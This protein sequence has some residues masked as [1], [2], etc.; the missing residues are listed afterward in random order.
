M[1]LVCG[2][3]MDI[4]KI[5]VALHSKMRFYF[6]LVRFDCT[7]RGKIRGISERRKRVVQEELLYVHRSWSYS[8]VSAECPSVSGK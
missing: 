6:Q 4:S 1:V 8:G 5:N 3:E 7:Y 2:K